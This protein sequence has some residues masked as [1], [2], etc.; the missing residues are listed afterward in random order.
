MTK[1][2]WNE[3]QN[4]GLLLFINQMLHLFGWAI[5]FEQDQ[6]TKEITNVYPAKVKWKGFSNTD[7]YESYAKITK[8]LS[9]NLPFLKSSFDEETKE[10]FDL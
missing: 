6:E 4:S 9:D 2:S 7:V 3:F 8:H 1:S 10:K 5:V